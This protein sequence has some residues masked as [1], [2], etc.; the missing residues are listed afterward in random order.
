VIIHFICRGNAF[1]SIIAE[2]YLNSLAYQGMTVR[3]SGTVAQAHK[4]SNLPHY[5]RTLELLESRGIREFAKPGYG[6]QL[7]PQRLADADIAVCMNGRVYND[8]VALV[9]FPAGLQIW[10]VAD[11][12][13]PG[14]ISAVSSERDR[15]REEAFTEIA[16][17]VDTLISGLPAAAYSWDARPASH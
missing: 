14:R 17:N 7:S 1:R 2:A 10:S 13:E 11:V 5:E 9:T 12:G 6:D 8:A 15:F 16:H 3:S 4:A